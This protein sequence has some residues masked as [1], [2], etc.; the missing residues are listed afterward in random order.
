MGKYVLFVISERKLVDICKVLKYKDKEDE[1]LLKHTTD[2][3]MVSVQET[4]RFY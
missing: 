2:K 3:D 1:S 4:R